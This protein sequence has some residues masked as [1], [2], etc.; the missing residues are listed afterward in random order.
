[1]INTKKK[2]V[3]IAET[4]SFVSVNYILVNLVREVFANKHKTNLL[5]NIT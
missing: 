2:F 5:K 4:I 3:N 1:M